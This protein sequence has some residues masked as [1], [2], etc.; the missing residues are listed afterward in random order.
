MS[1]Q[2]KVLMVT[3]TYL[4]HINGAV[5]Q[6]AGIIQRLAAQVHFQVLTG[7]EERSPGESATKEPA[8]TTKVHRIISRR[9]WVTKIRSAWAVARLLTRERFD[10]IHF[11]GFSSKVLMVGPM[12]KLLGAK[13]V[14]KCTSLGV[15]DA[16]SIAK[17]GWV[18]N[19]LLTCIDAWICP[20]PAF[21]ASAQ[22]VS[23]ASDRLFSI[24]NFVETDRFRPG[25]PQERLDCRTRLKLATS[26]LVLLFVGHF[27][28]D[29]RPDFLFEAISN[30]LVR[31]RSVRLILI[32]E[33][34]A[35]HFEVDPEVAAMI[36]RRAL[37]LGVEDQLIWIRQHQRMEEIFQ[38][39]DIFAMPSI[40][41]GM[42][43]ALAEAMSCEL[44]AVATLLPGITDWMLDSG[45]CG[46]LVPVQGGESAFAKAVNELLDDVKKRTSI[47]QKARQRCL[48]EFTSEEVTAKLWSMYSHLMRRSQ[49]SS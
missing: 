2:P 42:P 29:K 46:H 4:P 32:G 26:D 47:G 15:D 6:C 35:N 18:L 33:T 7:Q 14:L 38:A 22:R 12:A 9:S 17:R 39:V 36:R 11:H 8:E 5:L 49:L 27:S 23:L 37:V 41:E 28:R 10:I 44:P 34:S 20:S 21:L 40:R 48:E 24:P 13:V 30:T 25:T 16:E 19:W 45:R 3:G 1:T 43:N 31:N